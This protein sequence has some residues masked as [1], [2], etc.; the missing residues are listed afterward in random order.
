MPNVEN[1]NHEIVTPE[2]ILEEVRSIFRGFV[3]TTPNL[4][5]DSPLYKSSREIM[6]KSL[7]E[8]LERLSLPDKQAILKDDLNDTWG[9]SRYDKELD[10]ELFLLSKIHESHFEI[11]Y[12]IENR[13]YWR[14]FINSK[15]RSVTSN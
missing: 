12:G 7:K 2:A 8:S 4:S 10:E 9:R 13:P 15:K 1:G 3:E 5:P 14:D 11:I 6:V